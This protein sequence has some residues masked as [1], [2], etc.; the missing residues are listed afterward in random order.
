VTVVGSSALIT[1]A[2]PSLRPF[3]DCCIHHRVVVLYI[4]VIGK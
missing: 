4:M 3:F 1:P 2:L